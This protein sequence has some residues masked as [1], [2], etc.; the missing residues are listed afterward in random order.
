MKKSLRYLFLLLS[1]TSQ[2][3]NVG[4]GTNTPTERLDVNGNVNVRGTIKIRG[5]AGNPG[6]LLQVGSDGISTWAS[7]MGYKHSVMIGSSGSWTV[8][9]GVREIMVEAI[10]PGGGGAKGG[11]GGGGGYTVG[12]FQVSPNDVLSVLQGSK[13]LGAGLETESG[14]IGTWTKVECGSKL[15]VIAEPGGSATQNKPGSGGYGYILGDSILSGKVYY[16]FPGE[17]TI[18]SYSQ[19]TATEYVTSRKYG[20]GGACMYNPNNFQ[21]GAFLSFNTAT[22][23]NISLIYNSG[24]GGF[25]SGGGGGHT[26]SGHWGADGNYGIVIISW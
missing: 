12:I 7:A 22:L 8:G 9:P 19:R 23:F 2:A 15:T 10:G 3:Q 24:A 1:V 5:N 6:D 16:G 14:Q 26:E 11:G 13:G 18:E 17:P 25:G 4:V 20:N 21:K